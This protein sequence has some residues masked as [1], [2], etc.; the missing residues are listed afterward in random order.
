MNA[1]ESVRRDATVEKCPHFAF[2]EKGNGTIALLLV[3]Q[4]GFKIFR[5][6]LIQR[7]ILGVARSVNAFG[8]V[9]P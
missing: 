2:H 8:T 9:K 3:G 1:Y 5:N 7:A 6:N 4:K